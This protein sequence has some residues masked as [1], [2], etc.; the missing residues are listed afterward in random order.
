MNRYAGTKSAVR[1][2]YFTLQTLFLIALAAAALASCTRKVETVPESQSSTS[3][4]ETHTVVVKSIDL[5]RGLTSDR[6]VITTD[7]AFSPGDSVYASVVLTP[8]V[9]ATHAT[10]RWTSSD[11][12]VVYESTQD[13]TPSETEAVT[14]FV[15]AK[16]A[17]LAPGTYK[18]DILSDGE[19]VS[20][21]DFTV[22]AP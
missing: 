22:S 13:V 6:R 9:P 8:P 14:Q 18:L 21:K 20:S 3:T 19:V 10:A 4:T 7:Q 1:K 15:M 11:G 12:Q 17:G 5:G 2:S 16:P